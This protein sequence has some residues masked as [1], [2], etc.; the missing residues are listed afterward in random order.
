MIAV[1]AFNHL[2]Y[3]LYHLIFKKSNDNFIGLTSRVGM[4]SP[5]PFANEIFTTAVEKSLAWTMPQILLPLSVSPL[6][7]YHM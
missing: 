1:R 3:I 6:Y 2:T 5:S 4:N 7:L